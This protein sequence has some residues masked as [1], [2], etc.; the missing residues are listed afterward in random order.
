MAWRQASNVFLLVL[1]DGTAFVLLDDGAWRLFLHGVLVCLWCF[2]LLCAFHPFPS[3][4]R[5]LTRCKG[6]WLIV[7]FLVHWRWQD[8]R[9]SVRLAP[10][11]IKD[12]ISQSITRLCI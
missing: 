12:C 7:H 6:I 1:D 2:W 10:N 4:V 9:R 3:F 11:M 5:R 8:F